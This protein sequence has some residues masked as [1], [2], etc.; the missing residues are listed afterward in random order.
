MDKFLK[1][2]K[3]F[4]FTQLIQAHSKRNRQPELYIL[5]KQIQFTKKTLHKE[6]PGLHGFK[7][8]F[9]RKIKEKLISIL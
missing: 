8:K 6:T 1:R 4:Y 5:E 7:G 2:H 3:L 9:Y